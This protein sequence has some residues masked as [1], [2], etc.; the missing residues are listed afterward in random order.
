[1]RPVVT[2]DVCL[3][4]GVSRRLVARGLCRRCWDTPGTRGRHPECEPV[5]ARPW[6]SREVERLRAMLAAGRT[7]SECAA[8]L[9]RSWGA[10]QQAAF[11]L[12][13]REKP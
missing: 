12:D 11:R 13:L 3:E 9:D 1:M 7:Y 5:A 8:A 10:V 2:R 6:L 4:C